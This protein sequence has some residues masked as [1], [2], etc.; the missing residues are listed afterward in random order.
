MLAIQLG[1]LGVAGELGIK[2]QGGLDTPM[3]LPPKGKETKE[4]G[5]NNLI[6]SGV[7]AILYVWRIHG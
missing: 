3:D 1:K 6:D 2:H 5:K 4:L 7:C